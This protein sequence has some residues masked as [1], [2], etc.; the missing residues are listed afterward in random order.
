MLI[1][2][3]RSRL[4]I[5]P[6]IAGC[7]RRKPSRPKDPQ[8][9]GRKARLLF[10][11][12]E[13]LDRFLASPNDFIVFR[14]RARKSIGYPTESRDIRAAENSGTV[15]QDERLNRKKVWIFSGRTVSPVPTQLVQPE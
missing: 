8:A 15:E 10:K 13:K 5:Q 9:I 6:Q 7:N 11:E 3:D 14:W 1:I 2:Y 4:A 12:G